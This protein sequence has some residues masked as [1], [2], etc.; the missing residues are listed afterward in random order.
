[1]I[2]TLLRLG[3]ARK[4]IILTGMILILSGCASYQA[5]GSRT[6][7]EFTDDVGIQA[8]VKTAL[9]RDDELNGLA[10]NVEVKRSVVSLY[11]RIPSE[12]ARTK[13]LGLAAKVRGVQEVVDRLTLVSE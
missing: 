12:Y 10:I 13:A 8:A 1:M 9:I 5:G 6:I 4:S 11:G 3:K 2:G 7:G